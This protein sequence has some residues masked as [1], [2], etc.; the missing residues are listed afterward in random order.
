MDFDA[1]RN[2]FETIR[3]LIAEDD[4]MTLQV[5]MEMCHA[6]GCTVM[7]AENGAVAVEKFRTYPADMIFVDID[8]P[9]LDGCAVAD[10]IRMLEKK[11][12]LP[13][14]YMVAVTGNINNEMFRRCLNA[15]VNDCQEKP[16]TLAL[17]R[18]CLENCV[19]RHKGQGVLFARQ[20]KK[21]NNLR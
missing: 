14:S 2:R 5:A 13:E 6:F 1:L 9:D 20:L 12:N 16:Y 3:V 7:T 19:A 21:S 8:M 10:E 11:R 18:E 4:R 15:G 17:V